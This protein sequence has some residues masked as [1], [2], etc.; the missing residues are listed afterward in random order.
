MIDRRERAGELLTGLMAAMD[1]E[2]A[3]IW[4][5]MPG[6]V[7][8]FDPVKRTV[9]VQPA[10]RALVTDSDGS[11]SWVTMP[12]L[13]D[14]PVVFPGGGGFVLTIPLQ[15]GDE[16]L[17]VFANR[18]IDAW[19]QSGGVQNQ[20]EIRMHSLSDGFCVPGI[21]SVPE[22]QPNISTTE[23]HLRSDDG[24]RKVRIS[25]TEIEA[26]NTP[27]TSVKLTAANVAIST[28]AGTCQG[29]FTP[30]QIELAQGASSRVRLLPAE[31]PLVSRIELSH[32]GA[33]VRVSL[34]QITLTAAVIE[35]N[36]DV[37]INGVR[38]NLHRHTGVTIGGSQSGTVAGTT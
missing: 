35:L 14:C 32:I 28:G 27:D 29:T 18:C 22:V 13:V 10:L 23:I 34:S 11:Q 30:T 37:R 15:L 7:Q 1:G 16:V 25:D 4:T 19:W 33:L 6:I 3:N 2:R 26:Q 38:Y 21:T 17:M 8:S 9:V 20:A 5:A 24:V 12:L 31:G 36:G